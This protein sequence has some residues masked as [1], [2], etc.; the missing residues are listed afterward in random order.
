M[1]TLRIE[2]PPKLI[3]IFAAPDKFIRG[4]HGGRG[5]AKT[6]SFAKMAA[7][8]GLM[9]AQQ[10]IEGIILCARE[11]MNSLDD[12]SME[13]VKAAIASEPWLAANY[14]VGEKFI[15]TKDGRVDFKFAGLHHNLDSIKS[16]ARILLCWVD[17]A[18]PVTEGAWQKLIPTIRESVSELWV[19]WNPELEDSATDKRFRKSTAK[20]MIVVEINW[21]D[22]PWFPKVLERTRLDDQLNRPDQYEHIWEGGYVIAHEGA[23]FASLLEEAK[24]KKRIC[25]LNADPLMTYRSYHDIGGAGAKADA[26][27]IWVCQFVDR[28]IRVLDHYTSQGQT[29]A[30]HV[31]WMRSQGYGGAEI[32]LPHDGINAN[33]VSGKTYDQHWRDAGFKSV[34]V[35]PNQGSGAAKMRI[36]AAR[37]LFPRIYFDED[38]TAAG[39]KA[40]GWY[41]EKMDDKRRIGLGPNHDWSSHDADSFGLMCMDYKEPKASQPMTLQ[42]FGAV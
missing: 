32:I 21:R 10:G 34:R 31:Q 1:T 5:S 17:E 15:R 30:Y 13:E 40:L 12:S 41:H 28:E 16:K 20:D 6:R 4:A 29:L 35:I 36:E 19:T 9:F 8:R 3:P 25:R 42:N 33:N 2:L 11:Y 18:E 27:S 37:R 22:N 23:Y 38:T 7:V 39:R 24:R 26:Y 14:E